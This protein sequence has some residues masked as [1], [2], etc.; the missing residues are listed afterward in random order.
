M[1]AARAGCPRSTTSCGR[2]GCR[3]AIEQQLARGGPVSV[4][5]IGF[6]WGGALVELAWRFRDAPAQFAGVNPEPELPVERAEDLAVVAEA[7]GI[8]PRRRSRAS[9]GRPCTSTTPRHSGSRT[10]ASTSCTPR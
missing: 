1:R 4:L 6:G 5:E 10:R 9:A 8:V 7:L 3:S 2:S